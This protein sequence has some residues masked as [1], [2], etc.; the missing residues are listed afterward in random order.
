MMQE[1]DHFME[2]LDMYKPV[3][4]FPLLDI[5]KYRKLDEGLPRSIIMQHER[6]E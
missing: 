6:L 1:L 5:F 2:V 3:A 4:E